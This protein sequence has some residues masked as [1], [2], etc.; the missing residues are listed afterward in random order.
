MSSPNLYQNGI[1]G[2]TGDVL[3]TSKPLWCLNAADVWYV[4]SGTGVD[5]AS[6]AGKQ[7]EK[8]LA[9]TAQAHTNAAAGDIIVYLSGHVE[10]IA[11]QL[12]LTKARLTFVSE[13]TGT[14]RARLTNGAATSM[15]RVNTAGC[16][17]RNIYFPAPTVAASFVLQNDAS[18]MNLKD[19]YFECGSVSAVASVAFQTGA[20]SA[21]VDGCTFVATASQPGIAIEVVNA[22]SFLDVV[23]CTFDGGSYGFSDYAFKGTAAVTGLRGESNNMLNNTDVILATGSSGYWYP[24]S[25]SGSARFVQTA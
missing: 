11:A 24:G 9:T 25:T 17:F 18:N 14:S 8:P 13:G 16:Q 20:G 23:S 21:R 7:R 19:C 1:G 2:S 15:I 6:P 5:A 22:M 12:V 4:S 10:A 3:A